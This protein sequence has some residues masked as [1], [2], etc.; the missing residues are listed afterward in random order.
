V[1]DGF[2]RSAG[3]YDERVEFNRMGARRL[4]ASLPP[5]RYESVLDVACGTGFA[6]LAMI[7]RFGVGRVT[8]VDSSAAMIERARAALGERPGVELRLHQGDVLGM[9]VPEGAFDA[10][11]CAMALHWFPDRGAA[12][13]AM[14]RALRPGGVLGIVA[15]S[16]GH[17]REFAALLMGEDPPLFPRLAE[18]FEVTSISAEALGG[19]IA[20]AVLEPL[21]LWIEERRR[22]TSPERYLARVT[23]VGSHL[24]D[25]VPEDERERQLR[26]VRELMAGTSGDGSWSYTFTKIFAVARA[27]AAG[28]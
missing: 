20:A 26:R 12:V 6:S 17:D 14:A 1:S 9:P 25:D 23:T 10:V 28:A 8:G 11:L 22:R 5:D 16:V 4:V 2:D 19:F 21:D 24:I 7:E 15:P 3:E 13:A 27:P 18:T